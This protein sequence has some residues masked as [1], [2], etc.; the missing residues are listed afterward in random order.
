MPQVKAP[1]REVH[2]RK[3]L[4]FALAIASSV[5]AGTGAQRPAAAAPDLVL[6]NGRI[7]TLEAAAP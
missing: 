5:V 1:T 3:P 7:Y 4:L 6:V 2:V